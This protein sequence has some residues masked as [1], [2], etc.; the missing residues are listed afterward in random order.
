MSRRGSNAARRSRPPRILPLPEAVSGGK[1]WTITES[2][3]AVPSADAEHRVMVVPTRD[4]PH[5]AA[6]RLH[7]MAHARWS[8]AN[9]AKLI[10]AAGLLH[11]TGNACEDA[12][13]HRKL[14]DAGFDLHSGERHPR[15]LI[16]GHR[17]RIISG[18]LSALDG[19]CLLM[20]TMGTGE[21][22][23]ITQAL[24]DGGK[25]AVVAIVRDVYRAHF[26]GRR[27]SFQ[28]TIAAALIL[29]EWFRDEPDPE[30]LEGL[31]YLMG[32]IVLTREAGRATWGKMKIERPAMPLRLPPKIRA[33][34]R[35]AVNTGTVPRYW[36]R[37]CSDGAVFS[38]KSKRVPG[39][40]V[41]ID[42]SGS[43]SFTPDD[44]LAILTAAPAAI[45][46]TYAGTAGY[47]ILRVVAEN[48]RRVNDADVWIEMKN[49]T[50]DGPAL[51]WL[52]TY[53][54]PRYWVSDGEATSPAGDA[55]GDAARI[56]LRHQIIRVDSVD[57]LTARL[58]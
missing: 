1:Q 28:K 33:R 18:Q 2:Q 30:V 26:E 57:D 41:L 34:S 38:V 20:A 35:R 39:A 6:M 46:G 21:Q 44:V 3:S 4:H 5:D 50:I 49:N 16:E 27:P 58:G 53:P 29:E 7:E 52:A 56:A 13:V 51:E 40:A 11:F 47:G 55:I 42:Q 12:R 37:Y 24:N 14:L 8:P 17:E 32:P 25:G 22:D 10:L 23:A 48:G 54:G 9:G 45:V 15:E 43:M 19:A 31:G 36:H